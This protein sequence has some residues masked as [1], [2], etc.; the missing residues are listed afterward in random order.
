MFLILSGILSVLLSYKYVNVYIA[1]ADTVQL[2]S[3]ASFLLLCLP[4]LPPADG[5]MCQ[6]PWGSN[7]MTVYTSKKRVHYMGLYQV[8]QA[9]LADRKDPI[10][11]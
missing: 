11:R 3:P 4:P 8:R 5:V 6:V 2:K 1:S 9:E 7:K 10:N